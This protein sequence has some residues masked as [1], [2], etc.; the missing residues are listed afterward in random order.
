MTLDGIITSIPSMYG[1]FIGRKIEEFEE[2][3]KT[4]Q[5]EIK[6]EEIPQ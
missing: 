2:W 5:T 3:I 4:V 6:L 1:N